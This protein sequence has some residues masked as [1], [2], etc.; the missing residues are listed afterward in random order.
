MEV[1]L[2][3]VN[4]NIWTYEDYR[5]LPDDRKTYQ[6]IGGRLLMT[7]A[8]S[9]RHQ[10]ICRDLGFIIWSFVKEHHSGKV[11]NA[12]IDVIFS[13]VNVVQPDL[14]FI[15]KNRLKTIKEKGIF[16]APDWIIEILPPSSDKI[17][18]K[19]KRDLYQRFGVREYWIVYPDE[20]KV[21]VYL[22]REAR[23]KLKG[24]FSRDET[25]EVNVIENLKVNLKEIFL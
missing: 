3:E 21:E 15:S 14:V 13:S 10:D 23:Y 24:T 17:D 22:L 5:G 6:I 11:Y 4:E 8:P 12:P 19:L 7:P 20:E 16:G 9:T 25:L 2:L 18:I 1:P